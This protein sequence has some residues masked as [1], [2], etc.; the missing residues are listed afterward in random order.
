MSDDDVDGVILTDRTFGYDSVKGA[1][2]GYYLKDISK[3]ET[4]RMLVVSLETLKSDY[5]VTYKKLV[6]VSGDNF[7]NQ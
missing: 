3:G 1:A 6:E 7:P 4:I 5:P 2:I